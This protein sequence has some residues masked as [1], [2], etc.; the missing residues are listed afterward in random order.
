MNTDIDKKEFTQ[1][2]LNKSLK[3]YAMIVYGCL[4][5]GWL[6]GGVSALVGI[7]L[8]H[9]TK[10]KAVGT[11]YESHYRYQMRTFY[12]GLLWMIIG[13]ITSFI[14]IGY[15]VLLANSLWVTY[16]TIKGFMKLNDGETI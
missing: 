14:I 6:L 1:E 2:T 7:V 16:R 5:A 8:N 11:I 3:T 13:I 4:L 12:F 15:F 10:Y 9:T